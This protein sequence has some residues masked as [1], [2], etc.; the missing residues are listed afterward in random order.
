VFGIKGA[1]RTGFVRK[2]TEATKGAEAFQALAKRQ[3]DLLVVHLVAPSAS[4]SMRAD[5]LF[6]DP[7]VI[8]AAARHPHDARARQFEPES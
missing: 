5:V 8:A 1:K 6:D 7:H 4:E 2:G 3:V